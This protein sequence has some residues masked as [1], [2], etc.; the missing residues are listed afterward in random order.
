MSFAIPIVLEV[1][2]LAAIITLQIFAW[3]RGG[4]IFWFGTFF[5]EVVGNITFFI[6]MGYY[7][8]LATQ[9][10]ENAA[11]AATTVPHYGR[12]AWICLIFAFFDIGFTLIS[13]VLAIG[14]HLLN[15]DAGGMHY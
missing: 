7:N 3:K 14:K 5:F 2:S 1:L 4:S 8:S 15:K 13:I 9:V 12:Y 11:L 10:R 6:M